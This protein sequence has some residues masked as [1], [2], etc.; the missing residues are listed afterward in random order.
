VCARAMFHFMTMVTDLEEFVYYNTDSVSNV[1][2][3]LNHKQFHGNSI[4]ANGNLDKAAVGKVEDVRLLFDNN[5]S[6]STIFPSKYTCTHTH[7][8]QHTKQKSK[9]KSL[10]ATKG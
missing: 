6:V 3:E 4:T 2:N 7:N 9:A 8:T 1:V 10:A 5:E